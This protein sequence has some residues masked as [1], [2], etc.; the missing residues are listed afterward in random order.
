MYHGYNDS[1]QE[2]GYND[3][4]LTTQLT[5]TEL[6]INQENYELVRYGEVEIYFDKNIALQNHF[7]HRVKT[8]RFKYYQN[9]VEYLKLNPEIKIYFTLNADISSFK[10]TSEGILIN[11][12]A[13][14]QF[15]KSIQSKT[16]G[17]LHAFLGQNLDVLTAEEKSEFIRINATDDDV[18]EALRSFDEPTRKNIIQFINELDQTSPTHAVAENPI[19]LSVFLAAFDRF[20]TDPTMQTAFLK[21]LPQVQV[22]TLKSHVEFLKQNLDKNETFIQNWIDEEEGKHRKKRCLIFGIEYV[23]PKREGY[24]L[25][26]RFDILAEQNRNHHVLIELKSPNAEIFKVDSRPNG[27]GGQFTT[28]NL[29]SDLARALPQ[30]LEYKAWYESA[31]PEELQAMGITEGKRISK[32][33]IVIGQNIADQVW[34]D[35]LSRIRSSFNNVEIW[36]YT[37]LIEKLENTIANLE[38]NS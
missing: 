10:K 11:I 9:I 29:S 6:T 28:Y 32:C 16:S 38:Q 33:V 14:T 27:N 36:T 3:A 15:C 31:R 2:Q 13:Y 17:R 22:E 35:N 4:K 26:K 23:D 8:R 18:K 34:M 12:K 30:I 37:D 5:M 21:K 7:Q 19:S 24:L 25:T 20:V 1:T